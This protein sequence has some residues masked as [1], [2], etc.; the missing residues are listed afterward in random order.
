MAIDLSVPMPPESPLSMPVQ[1]LYSYNVTERHKSSRRWLSFNTALSRFIIF[2]GAAALTVY[3]TE[4]MYEVV[5]VGG[6]TPLEWALVFLFV[7]NFSWIAL[8]CSSA[9]VGFFSLL[10]R[11]PK[12]NETPASLTE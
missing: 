10:F 6:V 9:L 7:F 11:S 2:G 1:N 12:A 5:A 3:G 8:A 4:E